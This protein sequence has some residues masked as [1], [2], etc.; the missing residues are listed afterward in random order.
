[1]TSAWFWL[2][3]ELE[4]RLGTEAV[5]ELRAEYTVQ[6]RQQSK[7]AR[8]ARAKR[9]LASYERL[10]EITGTDYSRKIANRKQFLAEQGEL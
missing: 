5:A 8:I 9:E 4:R 6:L 2:W 3:A 7:E 1:M 10:A